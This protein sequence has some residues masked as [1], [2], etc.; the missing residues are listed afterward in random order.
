MVV[1]FPGWRTVVACAL[2]GTLNIAASMPTTPVAAADRDVNVAWVTR[3]ARMPTGVPSFGQFRTHRFQGKRALV[4][5]LVPPDGRRPAL[6]LAIADH[7]HVRDLAQLGLADLAPDRLRALVDLD[8]EVPQRLLYLPRV[9][10]V[11][12]GHR[13][14]DRLH[15]RQPDG[16]LTRVVL[17]QD[18][19]EPLVG[20][21]ERA[22]DHHRPVFG[23]VGAGEG[24]LEALGEVVV[25]LDG[26]ELP[27]AAQR[28]AHVKVDLRA[29]EGAVALIDA[30]AEVVGLERRDERGLRV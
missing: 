29:V 2:N 15:G 19:D 16:K 4:A 12:V 7:E 3:G 20:P 22:V 5:F 23:V 18:P 21:H 14:H 27:R 25:E 17:D 28:V 1:T 24:Q 9:L 26:P 13:Q 6:R 10:D 11:T 30:V 8:A